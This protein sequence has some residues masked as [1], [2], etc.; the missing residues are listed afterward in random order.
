[1]DFTDKSPSWESLDLLLRSKEDSFER[2]D[3]ELRKVGRGTTNH[4]T[5][6]RWF[7]SNKDIEPQITLYRDSAGMNNVQ[8]QDISIHFPLLLQLYFL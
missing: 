6:I 4:K 8:K 7:D 5:N 2:E 3:F 1:M